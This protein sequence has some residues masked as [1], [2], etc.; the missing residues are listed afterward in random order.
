MLREFEAGAREAGKNPSTMP[1]LIELGVALTE[2]VDEA[3]QLHK[4]YWGGTQLIALFNRKIYAPKEVDM[5][6]QAVGIDVI[7]QRTCMSPDPADHI[8]FARG[9]IDLGFDHLIFHS[10]GPDQQ[11]F[12]EN[13]GRQVLPALR[14]NTAGEKA[15]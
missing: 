9:Y 5:N 14:H 13:Y 11:A 7:K 12:I 10:P 6:A 8:R 3:A 2:S 1:R 15:A 4:Q